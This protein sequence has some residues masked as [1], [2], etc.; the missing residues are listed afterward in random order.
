[1]LRTVFLQYGNLKYAVQRFDKMLSYS[2]SKLR[3]ARSNRRTS[4]LVTDFARCKPTSVPY[5][6]AAREPAVYSTQQCR[7]AAIKV[8]M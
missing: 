3:A 8:L 6:N 5:R 4:L 2:E 7:W 1:M